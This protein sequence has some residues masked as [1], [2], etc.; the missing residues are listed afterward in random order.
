MVYVIAQDVY[1]FDFFMF[2][3]Q[4]DFAVVFFFFS[5][6]RRHTRCA[7]VTGVQTC[8]LPISASTGAERSSAVSS[9][10][11]RLGRLKRGSFGFS[12]WKSGFS[13]ARLR[14]QMTMPVIRAIV[15]MEPEIHMDAG[16]GALADRL[17]IAL[18]VRRPRTPPHPAGSA[19]SGSG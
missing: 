6:R 1:F 8:A 11:P 10:S 12:K 3:L 4:L 7:L 17:R 5:S 18:V 14:Y 19:T 13:S 16:S 15:M 2:P 9:P